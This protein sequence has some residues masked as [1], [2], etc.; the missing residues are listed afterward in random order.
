MVA[1]TH[2]CGPVVRQSILVEHGAWGGEAEMFTSWH[3]RS[4]GK[5]KVRDQDNAL[6]SMPQ[7]LVPSALPTSYL[8]LL[9]DN[10]TILI[11]V[12]INPLV[13]V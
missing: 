8:T 9:P 2:P 12:R 10:A 1:W 7:D 11:H 5:R 3:L 13:S 4:R 6:Q